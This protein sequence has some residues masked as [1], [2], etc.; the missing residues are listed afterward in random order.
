MDCKWG[1]WKTSSFEFIKPK[2]KQ[3]Q[4]PIRVTSYNTR[5]QWELK[6][7]TRKPLA[8]EN[9]GDQVVIGFIFKATQSWVNFD[10]VENCFNLLTPKILSVILLTISHTVL[11]MLV[12]RIWYWMSLLSPNWYFSLFSSLVCL[13]LYRYCKE[14]FCHGHSWELK[15]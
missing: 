15:G 1:S 9:T 2:P 5:S 12:W 3:S 4:Q 10:W 11:V 8:R 7:K 14:K 13:I 6:M